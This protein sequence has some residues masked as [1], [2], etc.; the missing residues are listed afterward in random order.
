MKRTKY[1]DEDLDPYLVEKVLQRLV[2][3]KII[4][5]DTRTRAQFL[6]LRNNHSFDAH[7]NASNKENIKSFQLDP[8]ITPSMFDKFW[9]LYPRKVDKGFAQTRWNKICAKK[10]KTRPTWRMVENAL[11]QQKKS[12]RWTQQPEFIPYPAS[13]LNKARWL[14]DPKEMKAFQTL[15]G[16]QPKEKYWDGIRYKL[17]GDGYY[18]NSAGDRWTD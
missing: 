4:T 17:A 18:Y 10:D 2:E 9:S 3:E 11:Y 13:W 1:P 5:I 14:D 7:N 15:N 12:E 16:N 6:L 8:L